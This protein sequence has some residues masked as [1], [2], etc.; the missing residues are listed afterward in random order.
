L[1]FEVSLFTI[2]LV[3]R[4]SLYLRRQWLTLILATACGLLLV[5]FVTG[6]LGMRDLMVLR[7]RRAQLET[8]HRELVKSNAALKLKLGRLRTDDHYLQRR[9]REQLG[10]VRPDELVYRFATE[11]TPDDR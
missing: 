9:I 3:I 11:T 2:L 8:A 1:H 10:Y 6:P 4:L 5:D 7:G